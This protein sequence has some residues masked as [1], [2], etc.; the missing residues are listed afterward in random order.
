[1]FSQTK[2]SQ[3]LCVTEL[4]PTCVWSNVGLD[5]RL[6]RSLDGLLMAIITDASGAKS[7]IRPWV[8]FESTSVPEVGPKSFLLTWIYHSITQHSLWGQR[9]SLTTWTLTWVPSRGKPITP[10]EGFICSLAIQN[11]LCWR[12]GGEIESRWCVTR[13]C[14]NVITLLWPVWVGTCWE[15]R[16]E[17]FHS[18]SLAWNYRNA[19]GKERE[20]VSI[21]KDGDGKTAND[22]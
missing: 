4:Q 2:T 19:N 15:K 10:R 22:W 14:R 20:L 17:I 11:Y 9:R 21:L 3:Y 7:S 6:T 13:F 1:M 5:L 18:A 16:V 12:F 8:W